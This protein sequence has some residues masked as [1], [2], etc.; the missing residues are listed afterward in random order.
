VT[1]TLLERDEAL[2]K[3]RVVAVEFE[4]ELASTRAQLQQDRTTLEGLW[5]LESQAEGKA[6]RPSN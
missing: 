3:V 1:T 4:T 6:N 5:S 2:R